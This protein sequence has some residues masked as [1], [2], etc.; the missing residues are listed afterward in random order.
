[1]VRFVGDMTIVPIVPDEAITLRRLIKKEEIHL[2]RVQRTDRHRKTVTL[3]QQ[4]AVIGRPGPE[5]N[6]INRFA[7]HPK[8][9]EEENTQN[10]L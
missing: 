9:L 4:H 2:H 10:G 1:M 6:G 3:R 7:P 8:F 5:A